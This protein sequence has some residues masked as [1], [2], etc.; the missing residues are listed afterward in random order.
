L[1]QHAA[2]RGILLIYISSDY[3]F[4]GTMGD[5]PY[6]ASSTPQPTNL[7]GITKLDGEKAVLD[8]YKDA[9]KGGRG[10]VLR[11]PVLYGKAEKPG[12]SAVNV[13]VESVWK[14]QKEEVKIDHWAKRFPTNTEDVGRVIAGT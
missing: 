7:Y 5:A 2:A 9:G 4:P 11:V 8:A 10:V 14:S 1:A 12:E 3:V 6:S 13:L